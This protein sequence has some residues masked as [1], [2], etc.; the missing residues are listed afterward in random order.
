MKYLFLVATICGGSAFAADSVDEEES[1]E[2][3]GEV[4][5]EPERKKCKFKAG[6]EAKKNFHVDLVAKTDVA[7]DIG[8]RVDVE[9]PYRLRLGFSA[10]VLPA[11][12]VD[13]INAVVVALG[14]YDDVTAALIEATIKNSLIIHTDIGWRPFPKHGFYFNTG[15]Q[16]ATLGG[17]LSGAEVI[18]AAVGGD[19]PAVA[20]LLDFDAAANLHMITVS[21]GWDIV[22]A[23]HFLI[24]PQLGGAFTVASKTTIEP[25]FSY[26]AI[27]SGVMD[28]FT[29]ESE[30]YLDDLFTSWVHTPTIGLHLGWRFF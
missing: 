28:T 19:A 25:D 22:I 6:S 30:A 24:R 13:V 4:E 3:S 14:G 12:Y 27:F 8:G 7:L 16:L 11:P 10:G 17:G 5:A 2:A 26:P 9:L 18:E 15:Y 21:V 29:G 20:E 23:K 1:D